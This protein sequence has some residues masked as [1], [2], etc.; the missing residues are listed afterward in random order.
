MDL[1]RN[2]Q[3][4][5]ARATAGPVAVPDNPVIDAAW[6]AKEIGALR[7][8]LAAEFPAVNEPA[9]VTALDLATARLAVPA[10][11]PNYLP[12]LVGRDARRR[13]AELDQTSNAGKPPA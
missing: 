3:A 11:I 5:G 1:D 6:Y 9:I 10:R 13:L 2:T 4:E 7:M 12:V 8:K